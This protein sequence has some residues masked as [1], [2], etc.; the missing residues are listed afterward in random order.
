MHIRP[1]FRGRTRSPVAEP[2]PIGR[3][4]RID[5]YVRIRM[6]APCGGCDMRNSD[7]VMLCGAHDVRGIHDVCCVVPMICPTGI[8][9]RSDS[10]KKKELPA[11]SLRSEPAEAWILLMSQL[12]QQGFR[13]CLEVGIQ[14]QIQGS[15]Q[16]GD[17]LFSLPELGIYAPRK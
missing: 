14:P 7:G 11:G 13:L 8:P 16:V 12:V 10:C 2:A 6:G 4:D 9:V 5:Q 17:R 1:V 15:L 3:A